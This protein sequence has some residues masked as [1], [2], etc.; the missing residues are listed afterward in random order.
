[1]LNIFFFNGTRKVSEIN[2][3]LPDAKEIKKMHFTFQ[4]EHNKNY[5]TEF[6]GMSS[7]QPIAAKVNLNDRAF[8]QHLRKDRV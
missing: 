6:C 7:F 4:K 8:T 2:V 3:I 1:M 5:V